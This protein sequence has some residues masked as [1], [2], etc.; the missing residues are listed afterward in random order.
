LLDEGVLPIGA[1]DMVA[2]LDLFQRGVELALQFLG[3]AGAEDL[4]DLVRGH[5]PQTH[6]AGTFEDFMDGE[7]ALKDEIAAILNLLHGVKAAQVHGF[8]LAG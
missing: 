4:R 6:L 7:V 5:P 8:A 2:V 3:Q 1:E